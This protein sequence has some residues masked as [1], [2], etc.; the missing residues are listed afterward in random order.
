M[1][2]EK[3]TYGAAL[4]PYLTKMTFASNK[5]D[6]ISLRFALFDIENGKPQTKEWWSGEISVEKLYAGLKKAGILKEEVS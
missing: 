4:Q 6:S 5:R 2:E 3:A 1:S